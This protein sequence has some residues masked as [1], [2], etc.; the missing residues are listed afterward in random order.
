MYLV[1]RKIETPWVYVNL[2]LK[3]FVGALIVMGAVIY[4][5]YADLKEVLREFRAKGASNGIGFSMGKMK[6]KVGE[7]KD[8]G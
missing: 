7:G 1:I 5:E 8:R 2:L 3:I 4:K 6:E